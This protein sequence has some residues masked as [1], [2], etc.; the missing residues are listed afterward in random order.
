MLTSLLKD[1]Y[2]TVSY[3]LRIAIAFS[4]LYPPIAAWF[5]PDN[6]IWFV[7]D[8]I[9]MF[10]DK[11]VF[12]HIFG[13]FEIAIAL[14]LLFLKNPFWPAVASIVV[15]GAIIILDWSTFDIVFR[16]ISILLASVALI[17]LHETKEVSTLH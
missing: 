10:I 9:E 15:L 14:G 4:F 13:A 1:R 7:P 12:L 5:T 17:A 11:A 2:R 16:D 6:W 8:F 3:I